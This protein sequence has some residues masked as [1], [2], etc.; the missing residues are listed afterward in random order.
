MW[1][2]TEYWLHPI[3]VINTDFDAIDCESF[4]HNVILPHMSESM[5]NGDLCTR[6]FLAEGISHMK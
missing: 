1:C 3:V 4:A 5:G 6:L 2:Q